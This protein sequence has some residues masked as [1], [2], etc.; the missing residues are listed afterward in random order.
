MTTT[1][2]SQIKVNGKIIMMISITHYHTEDTHIDGIPY[3]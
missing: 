3:D 1:L 2:T